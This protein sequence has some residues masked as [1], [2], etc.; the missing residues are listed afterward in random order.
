MQTDWRG[1]GGKYQKLNSFFQ[2]IDISHHVSCPHAHQQNGSTEQKHRHIVDVGLSLL[3]QA[4]MPLKFWDVAFC[5]VVYLINRT[6]LRLSNMKHLLKGYS[7][8]NQIICLLEFLDVPAGSTYTLLIRAS[9]IFDINNVSSLAIVIST[10]VLS[11]L[12]CQPLVSTFLE[13]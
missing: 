3:V 10:K 8:P 11:A 13:M 1:G 5:V 6:P 9:F 4:S 7:K 12:T 2:H